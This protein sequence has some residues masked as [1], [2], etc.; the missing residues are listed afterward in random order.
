MKLVLFAWQ[1]LGTLFQL[2]VT[3]W[4][5]AL[6]RSF[7]VTMAVYSTRL[8]A[9]REAV[10][11]SRIIWWI[12]GDDADF[13]SVMNEML[14]WHAVNEVYLSPAAA[15]AFMTV[16]NWKVLVASSQG[17]GAGVDVFKNA[18]AA[19]KILRRELLRFRKRTIGELLSDG[20]R[21]LNRQGAKR[22]SR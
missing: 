10:R 1:N 11:R 5:A 15:A 22:R 7:Q 6:T 12:K 20:W 18:E 9:H 17:M 4:L 13:T 14:D 21:S 8:E 16:E 19:M 3:I 2:L